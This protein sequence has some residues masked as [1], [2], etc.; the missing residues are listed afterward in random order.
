[1]M[2]ED[3]LKSTGLMTGI[4]AGSM[5]IPLLAQNLLHFLYDVPLVNIAIT[6]AEFLGLMLWI[7]P[8][9]LICLVENLGMLIGEVRDGG[10]VERRFWWTPVMF[11][12]L[13]AVKALFCRSLAVQIFLTALGLAGPG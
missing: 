9:A 6:V 4:A 7:V 10:Y 1:M 5:L 3:K 2:S 13:L 11:F 12:A 8:V